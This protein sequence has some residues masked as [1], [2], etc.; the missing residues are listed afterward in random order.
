MPQFIASL[1]LSGSRT[2]KRRSVKA[3]DF[4]RDDRGF[5]KDPIALVAFQGNS[6]C[7]IDLIFVSRD[8]HSA[9]ISQ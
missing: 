8:T 4:Y 5:A 3:H 9:C 1:A 7:P 6:P 2:D